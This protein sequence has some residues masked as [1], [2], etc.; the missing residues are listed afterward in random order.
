MYVRSQQASG[1]PLGWWT[2]NKY[3]HIIL[4]LGGVTL[5]LMMLPLN[6][7]SAKKKKC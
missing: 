1:L 2:V 6:F 3:E 5:P 7:A 4:L